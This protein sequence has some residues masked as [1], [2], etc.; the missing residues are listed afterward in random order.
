MFIPVPGSSLAEAE[1]NNL[2]DTSD[3]LRAI[4]KVPQGMKT[5]K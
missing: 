5:C 3:H 1:V 4:S 2:A